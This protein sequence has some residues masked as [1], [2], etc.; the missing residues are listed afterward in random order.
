MGC[1]P[2]SA[3]LGRLLRTGPDRLPQRNGSGADRDRRRGAGCD[4]ARLSFLLRQP[5]RRALRPAPRPAIM[6][7]MANAISSGV[8][9]PIQFFHMPV[10]RNRTDDGYFRTARK[11]A[12][13]ARKPSFISASSITTTRKA[14]RRGWRRRGATRLSTASPPNAAWR[15][16]I[17]RGCRR[18]SP[19]MSAPPG[20]PA[21]PRRVSAVKTVFQAGRKTGL[22]Y[23]LRR[24]RRGC[25]YW[26]ARPLLR[27]RASP[28]PFRPGGRR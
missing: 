10:P 17:R 14:T 21:D 1:V 7:E 18:S 13:A 22:D 16:A 24:R 8:R 4:R 11:S 5:G 27:L 28:A 25:P 23:D 9:R 12:P 2:G 3:G 6:V 15:A 26:R 20:P 19:P